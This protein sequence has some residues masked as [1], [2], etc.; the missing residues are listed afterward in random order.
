MFPQQPL[1]PS[2][3]VFSTTTLAFYQKLTDAFNTFEQ[4]LQKSEE[5]RLLEHLRTIL[6]T[7][8]SS[9]LA[10]DMVKRHAKRLPGGF[11]DF[12]YVSADSPRGRVEAIL[13]LYPR[14]TLLFSDFAHLQNQVRQVQTHCESQ[15]AALK[16]AVSNYQQATQRIEQLTSQNHILQ[17]QVDDLSEKLAKAEVGHEEALAVNRQLQEANAML[18]AENA[19]L[20]QYIAMLEGKRDVKPVSGDYPQ[21]AL[22]F[23]HEVD[24]K[25]QITQQILEQQWLQLAPPG[26]SLPLLNLGKGV[27]G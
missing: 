23:F 20:L 1:T 9:I 17:L 2:K 11:L 7:A 27:S 14:D 19:K 24:Q 10:H 22:A 12:V 13:A 8:E 6:N 16:K 21:S 26:E 5:K 18:Q 25:A 15:E 3:P 4:A